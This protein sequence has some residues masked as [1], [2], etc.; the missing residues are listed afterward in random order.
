MARRL[1]QHVKKTLRK[2]KKRAEE[3]PE[4]DAAREQRGIYFISDD[5]PDD[6][7]VAMNARSNWTSGG[8]QRCLAK[9]PN[10]PTGTVQA[11]SDPMQVIGLRWKRKD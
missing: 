1:V 11:E 9:S 5:D 6:R 2:A 8:P 10:Q 7:K 4:L 3:K